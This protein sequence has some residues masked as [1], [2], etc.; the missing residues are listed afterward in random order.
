MTTKVSGVNDHMGGISN[1][2]KEITLFLGVMGDR[3]KLS[4]R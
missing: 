3:Q 4:G 2:P 1:M